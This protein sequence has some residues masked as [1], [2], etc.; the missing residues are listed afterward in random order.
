MPV[1]WQSR[2]LVRSA[3]AIFSTI[4]PS[5]ALPVALVAHEP[6]ETLLDVAREELQRADIKCLRDFFDFLG[7]DLHGGLL[8]HEGCAG[9]DQQHGEGLTEAPVVEST[10]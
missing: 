9:N 5:T 6:L 3:T 4:V 1:S 7:V 10:E 2:L 8:Q